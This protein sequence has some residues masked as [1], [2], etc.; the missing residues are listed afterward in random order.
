MGRKV[1]ESWGSKESDREGK[2][3]PEKE[4]RPAEGGDPEKVRNLIS[5]CWA[6]E[7]GGQV[8]ADGAGVRRRKAGGPPG[9]VWS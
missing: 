4:D 8:G 7:R 3:E 1:L 2:R 6:V 5:G 9:N